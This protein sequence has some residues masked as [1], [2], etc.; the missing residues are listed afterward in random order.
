VIQKYLNF[1]KIA[2]WPAP[3]R[4]GISGQPLDCGYVRF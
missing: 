3:P 4:S 2:A 1:Q